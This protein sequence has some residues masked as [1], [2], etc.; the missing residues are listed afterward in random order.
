MNN[1]VLPGGKKDW[2]MIFCI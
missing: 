1:S 2:V